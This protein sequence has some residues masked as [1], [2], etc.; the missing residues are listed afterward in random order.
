VRVINKVMNH[1]PRLATAPQPNVPGEM[2][3]H[4]TP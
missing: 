4:A 3:I 1:V 2:Q